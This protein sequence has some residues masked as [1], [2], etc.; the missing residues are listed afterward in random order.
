MIK[1]YLEYI[2]KDIDSHSTKYNN[3][4]LLDGFNCKPTEEPRK[5]FCRIYNFKNLL[6]KPTC[7]KNH[8]NPSCFGL[9]ITNKPRSF[10]NTCMFETGLSDFHKMT[11]TV[12]K[13]SS[14]KQKPRVLNYRRNCKFFNNT[15][16]RDQVLNLQTQELK[17]ANKR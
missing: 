10:K 4:L 14:A 3:F 7:Y 2:S 6:D 16:L 17:F 5:S 9:I 13:S 12:L 1:R 15:L 11:L 8:T